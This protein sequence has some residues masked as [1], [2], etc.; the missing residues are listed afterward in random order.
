MTKTE[1]RAKALRFQSAHKLARRYG[2]PYLAVTKAIRA[3]GI[4][5]LRFGDSPGSRYY[6]RPED[7]LHWLRTRRIVPERKPR[8][9]NVAE[10]SKKSARGSRDVRARRGRSDGR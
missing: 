3:G 7:F 1:E 10:S 2:V 9:G 4:P 5:A 6:V 8:L